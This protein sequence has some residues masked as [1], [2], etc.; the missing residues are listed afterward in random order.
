M[1][2]PPRVIHSSA[3]ALDAANV[4]IECGIAAIRERGAFRFGLSGGNT[5]RLV[6]SELAKKSGELPWDKVRIT[7]GDER[8]VPPDDVQSNY[9]MANESL[10]RSVSMAEKNVFRMRGELPPD[11]A[12][13]EYETQLRAL[14]GPSGDQRYAHDLLLLGIGED[15][16]TA[17]LFPETPALGER[18]K[19]VAANYVPKLSAHRITLTYPEI[20]AAR[21]ILFLVND[22]AKL[23]VLE[24]IWN[25]DAALPATGVQPVSGQLTW[26]LG[27]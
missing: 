22:A 6:F 7:F 10:L 4:I 16:H 27:F 3:F 17:S 24:R 15:G 18:E 11:E 26:L 14:A 1:S 25:G 9:R 23:P 13:E 21:H 20:N 12:A 19:N 8:C 5:P 2:T